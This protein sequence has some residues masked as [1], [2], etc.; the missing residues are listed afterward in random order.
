MSSIQKKRKCRASAAFPTQPRCRRP[1][2]R[3]SP[4]QRNY[5]LPAIETWPGKKGHAHSSFSAQGSARKAR[6]ERNSNAIVEVID[7]VGGS[8]IGPNCTGICTPQHHSIFTEPIPKLDPKGVDFIS[9]SGATAC[10]I[11]EAG[12]PEGT[13]LR[14]RVLRRQQRAAGRGGSARAPRRE[15]RPARVRASKCCT[16][17]PS[18]NRTSCSGMP[19]RSS[20]RAA[21]SPRSKPAHPKPAAARPRRTPARSQAPMSPSTRC[22]ARP[23]SCA[24]TVARTL[25]P[26]PRCSCTRNLP[27]RIS[28]SSPMPAVRP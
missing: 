17:R 10:F 12:I 14:Q 8:L 15:L 3:S 16:S 1:I 9:G 18:A 19:A 24:A 5:T 21:A 11:L 13:D 27:E 20:A 6:P 28:P 2:S 7:S 4:S 23:A 25:S 26:S 22:S